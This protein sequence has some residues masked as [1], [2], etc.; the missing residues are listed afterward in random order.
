MM[1]MPRFIFT[2]GPAAALLLSLGL[3][4]PALAHA[5]LVSATP[6][7]KAMAMPPPTELRLKFSEG[8][9][10]KFSKV[11]LTGPDKKVIET[12][13]VRLAPGDNT[14]LIIPLTTPLPDGKYTV[15]WEVVSIDSHKTRGTYDFESMK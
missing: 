7:A 5:N 10:L 15:D 11:K 6:A 12:G 2:R 9:E 14:T 3:A 1:T 8:I 13:P 4:S